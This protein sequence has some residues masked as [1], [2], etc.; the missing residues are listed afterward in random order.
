MGVESLDQLKQVLVDRG[1]VRLLAKRLAAN[2]NAKNGIYLAGSLDIVNRIPFRAPTVQPNENDNPVIHADIDLAWLTDELKV[3]VSPFAKIIL[4]PQYPEVRLSG[5]LRG[6]RGARN[7]LLNGD[8]RIEGR[9]L[10]LGVRAD[11]SVL[12][13]VLEPEHPIARELVAQGVFAG[14]AILV[15]IALE[16]VSGKDILLTRLALI[17]DKEWIPSGRLDAAGVRH[18]CNA[19]NCGGCTL[20]AE[21]DIASNS[22]AEPDFHGWEVKQFGVR[23]F[24]RFAAR[25]PVTLFTPEPT[26]GV[27]ATDGVAVFIRRYGYADTKGRE[28]RLNVGGRFVVGRTL[29]RTGL[30]LTLAGFNAVTGRIEDA[31]GGVRLLAGDGVLAAGWPFTSLIEHWN[32][33]HAQAAF[34]PS[35]TRDVPRAYRYGRRVFLGIGSDF[36][37]FLSAVAAGTICYDPGIKLEGI[38][39]GSERAHRRSQFRIAFGKMAAVY[40]RFGGVDI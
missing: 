36:G 40:E 25:S 1:V 4:Y 17:A 30:T 16:S 38:G 28:N 9:I 3:T 11:R 32:R 12:G 34:V 31:A 35:L 19:P 24:V 5:Y 7:D 22:R 2:D 15:D 20:E 6:T 26:V 13:V 10:L 14:D 8:A 23:D 29:P 39:T 21:L 18:P 27:Y 37:R 33:K